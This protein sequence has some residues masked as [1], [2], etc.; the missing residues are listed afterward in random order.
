[1]QTMQYLPPWTVSYKYGVEPSQERAKA[2][3]FKTQTRRSHRQIMT[4]TATRRLVLSEL[5]Y[6]EW[7]IRGLCNNGQAKFIDSYADYNGLQAGVIRIVEGS[8]KVDTDL[9]E[10]IVTCEIEVFR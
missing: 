3:G 1:M 5:P 6:F 9:R 10:H 7:F 4:A 2:R 8:Y